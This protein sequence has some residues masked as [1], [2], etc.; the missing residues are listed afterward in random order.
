MQ[1]IT[2]TLKER[3]SMRLLKNCTIIPAK[4]NEFKMGPRERPMIIQ[5]LW[6]LSRLLVREIS[7]I[8]A[9]RVEKTVSNTF[10]QVRNLYNQWDYLLK[11]STTLQ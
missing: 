8:M 2:K 3:K 5:S 9:K 1:H 10:N 7:V 11:Y 4:V 6:K